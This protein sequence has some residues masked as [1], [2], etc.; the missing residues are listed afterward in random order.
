MNWQ[1]N[2]KLDNA[3][4]AVRKESLK[5]FE[6]AANKCLAIFPNAES[7]SE[8]ARLVLNI[9]ANQAHES[10]DLF[11]RQFAIALD[12]ALGASWEKAAAAEINSTIDELEK[13]PV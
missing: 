1:E 11:L 5:A 9:V 2:K 7:D 6:K 3:I 8:T 13:T 12:D 10:L 4:R